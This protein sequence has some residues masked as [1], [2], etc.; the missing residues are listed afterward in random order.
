MS[1]KEIWRPKKNSSIPETYS[2]VLKK[3]FY[4]PPQGHQSTS[5]EFHVCIRSE[6]L[7]LGGPINATTFAPS[8]W[9]LTESALGIPEGAILPQSSCEH[10]RRL[11]AIPRLICRC[12][13][14]KYPRDHGRKTCPPVDAVHL[15]EG[16]EDRNE[17]TGAGCE[18]VCI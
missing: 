4:F 10:I 8:H 14:S 16:F 17:A 15:R 3:L 2:S 6:G 7:L 18:K 5:S 13:H 9:A 12:S 11:V 1:P